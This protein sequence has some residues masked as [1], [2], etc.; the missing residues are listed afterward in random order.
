VNAA[1]SPFERLVDGLIPFLERLRVAGYRIEMGQILAAHGVLATMAERGQVPDDLHRLRSILGPILCASE[2]EQ[3]H[4]ADQF[5][6]W[7]DAIQGRKEPT[8]SDNPVD[9]ARAVKEVER[10]GERMQHRARPW[11]I[12]GAVL[13]SA[14]TAV[15]IWL[16]IPRNPTVPTGPPSID[17]FSGGSP[18]NSPTG[19]NETS[20]P[21]V[22]SSESA[23][24]LTADFGRGFLVVAGLVFELLASWWLI[25]R[26]S[27]AWFERAAERM[28]SGGGIP[29]GEMVLRRLMV[30]GVPELTTL[31]IRAEDV[32]PAESRRR[33]G[34]AGVAL[35]RHR[36][37]EADP[38]AVDVVAT[39]ARALRDPDRFEPVAAIRPVTPEYLVLVHRVSRR[40]HQA[41]WADA[42]LD[43]LAG[44]Q[45]ALARF[46][47][48]TDPRVCYP[49]RGPGP[50]WSLRELAARHPE[51]RLMIF[52]DSGC[53]TDPRTGRLAPWLDRLDA[54][55][56]RA[57]LTPLPRAAWSDREEAL[58]R[59]GILIES[60]TS[61]GLEAVAADIAAAEGAAVDLVRSDDGQPVPP[62][63]HA[64][65]SDPLRWL[66]PTPPLPDEADRLLANLRWYLKDD[67]EWLAACA[68]YPELR[69]DLT[70]EL[71]RV[72]STTRDR[73]ILSL[74][75][76]ARLVRLPWLRH[77]AMPD[78]LRLRLLK[79][80]A[81]DRQEVIR[82]S[83]DQL[84]LG[85]DR[86][87][88]AAL[89][90]SGPTLA[91]AHATGGGGGTR[92]ALARGVRQQL[93]RSHPDGPLNDY[94]FATFLDGQPPSPLDY[95]LPASVRALLQDG[96]ETA[97]PGGPLR[98][99]ARS[100]FLG[101]VVLLAHAFY[102]LS[103]IG[104]L[105]ADIWLAALLWSSDSFLGGPYVTAIVT[106]PVL[107]LAFL[108]WCAMRLPG[109]AA[110]GQSLTNLRF[111]PVVFWY[112][113]TFSLIGMAVAQMAGFI[114]G[115]TPMGAVVPK[116]LISAAVGILVL[117]EVFRLIVQWRADR[118][119]TVFQFYRRPGLRL[120]M[121]FLLSLLLGIVT[122]LMG[123][124]ENGELMVAFVVALLGMFLAA[125]PWLAVLRLRH[126]NGIV[127]PKPA[128]RQRPRLS[129]LVPWFQANL[130]LLVVT[131]G[132]VV[133]LS[134]LLSLFQSW[135]NP[136]D[137]GLWSIL[138]GRA[139]ALFAVLGISL[140]AI[141]WL[142]VLYV[143]RWRPRLFPEP[144]PDVNGVSAAVDVSPKAPSPEVQ[145]SLSTEL[146]NWWVRWRIA[147]LIGVVVGLAI[148]LAAYLLWARAGESTEYPAGEVSA[149]PRL[150][151][152]N[153]PGAANDLGAKN[154]GDGRSSDDSG[155]GPE[156][157]GSGASPPVK[158][159]P[160]AAE[161]KK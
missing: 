38:A 132:L 93:A 86:V 7:V 6:D 82:R 24:R 35:R 101:P 122:D 96:P 80:L 79:D 91:I 151:R 146:S 152:T 75:S 119:Q 103:W 78:W 76:L 145:S 34:R 43:R 48:A 60:A 62:L 65:R 12:A 26:L 157:N 140:L 124:S 125:G 84:L 22:L 115:T 61:A 89:E 71:G 13:L 32:W 141:P 154:P 16:M 29:G 104:I 149:V 116:S 18:K 108:Q 81:P 130:K 72:L 87:D 42:L 138:D 90:V 5:K 99:G 129:D 123:N 4:F 126:W 100:R 83:I 2:N 52:G 156:R 113:L 57:L 150:P 131:S 110:R 11:I 20:R 8:I 27:R 49:R 3:K 106:L 15:M 21:P 137:T 1:A 68:F 70:I 64:L 135:A 88:T 77:G 51:H 121:V 19:T 109:H 63:P 55:E 73:A 66:D 147:V 17:A 155:R 33:L 94:V 50:P 56:I 74:T 98:I 30:S 102:I 118:V 54:W 105:G 148:I 40:D 120:G 36:R 85:A 59:R 136:T 58:D 46:E 142:S 45:V 107:M 159:D 153:Y 160:P 133:A 67:F 14:L 139:L 28:A 53:L 158:A 112:L 95:H 134:G 127:F 111:A 31:K 97:T 114:L 23:T 10:L 144:S 69:W 92:G 44:E 39:L 143:R 128:P 37:V 47:F 25:R 41:D 9:V 117:T 161:P